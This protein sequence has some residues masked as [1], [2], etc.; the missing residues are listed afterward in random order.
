MESN[1]ENVHVDIGASVLVKPKDCCSDLT[2]LQQSVSSWQTWGAFHYAWPSGQR[3]VELT[4]GKWNDIFNRNKISNQTEAF[5]L[6]STEISITFQ[7]SGTGNANF[8]KWNGK[9]RSDRTDRSKRITSGGGTLFL[10]NV[11]LDRSVPFMFRPKFP[12]ILA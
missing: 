1:E 7:W 4:K 3:P 6:V 12:E 9:F 2:Y 11:L 10:E 8:W 5:H